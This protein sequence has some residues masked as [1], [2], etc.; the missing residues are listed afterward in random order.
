[1]SEQLIASNG[2]AQAE[3]VAVVTGGSRGVGLTIVKTLT[4]MGYTVHTCARKAS[5]VEVPALVRLTRLDVTDYHATEAWINQTLEETGRID[6]LVN[7]AGV[8]SAVGNLVSVDPDEWEAVFRVNVFAVM[9]LCRRV[10]PVMAKQGGGCIINLAGG[11]SAYP[12]K[13]FTAYACS[14]AAVVRL[15]DSLAEELKDLGIRVNAIG[16][17]LQES[18]IWRHAA[19]VGETL[20]S[21]PWD[22]PQDLADLI[23]FVVTTP[24]V[25]GKFLHI[26][27]KYRQAA[28]SEFSS[29]LWTLRR[30][31]PS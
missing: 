29:D 2:S 9:R 20:P 1:M 15:S 12:R 19:Q 31:N 27:D 10:I 7:N 4:Q 13:N 3:K 28:L 24:T 30:V 8:M 16:P 6:V 23:R 17:G 11:G 25:T 5:A 22:N 21:Q 26:K 18:E 14:K